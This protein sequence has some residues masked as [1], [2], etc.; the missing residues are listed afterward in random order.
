MTR[1]SPNSRNSLY[2]IYADVNK[3]FHNGNRKAL[4]NR[5]GFLSA[6]SLADKEQGLGLYFFPL[7]IS[8]LV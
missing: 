8:F 6:P 1:F 7:V 2:L 5:Q 4:T 3:I